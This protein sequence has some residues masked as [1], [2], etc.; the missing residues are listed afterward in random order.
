MLPPPPHHVHSPRTFS[1]PVPHNRL[2]ARLRDGIP[3]FGVWLTIP[4]PI[5]ARVLATQGFDWACIDMEHSPTNPSVMAE[6]VSAV[7]SSGTCTPIV[8]VPSHSPEWFKWALD[9][10]AHGIIVPM[11]NTRNEME[12]VKRLCKYPPEGSRSYGAFFAPQAF[13]IRGPAAMSEYSE[14]ANRDVM[15]IPQI[16][17]AEAVSNLP[18]ILSVGGIDAIFVGP[19]DLQASMGIK[20]AEEHF[21]PRL[22]SAL[23]SIVQT[24]E[25]RHIPRG[26][27]ASSGSMAR[28]KI[29]LGY[30]LLVAATDIGCL[31][32]S[33]AE[34][35]LR[36]RGGESRQYR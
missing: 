3:V 1:P 18:E 29:Q 15:V 4:S 12:R 16:E 32:A 31:S 33:A 24:A 35:L 26:I 13:G 36:A 25:A 9:A 17:S 11:V 8:R 14:R 19:Y 34:N 7:A 5:T 20:P 30:T 27:Y 28:S 6:M 10:G 21:D 22:L 2:K 23:N